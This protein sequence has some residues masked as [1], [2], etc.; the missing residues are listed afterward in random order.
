M[1][2]RYNESKIIM[3][4]R[5]SGGNVYVDLSKP[6]PMVHRSDPGASGTCVVVVV[7]ETVVS[8]AVD[9]LAVYVIGG[10][11]VGATAGGAIVSGEVIG[12]TCILV[13]GNCG[14]V[15]AVTVDSVAG[16]PGVVVVRA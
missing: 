7:V 5:P 11:C 2:L 9:R 14:G 10:A 13:L 16:V 3:V 8:G 12:V 15:A 1:L 4:Q 6:W